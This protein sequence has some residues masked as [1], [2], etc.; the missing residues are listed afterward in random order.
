M[1][2]VCDVDVNVELE[3][4]PTPVIIGGAPTVS[5]RDGDDKG[6]PSLAGLNGERF[7]VPAPLSNFPDE[8]VFSFLFTSNEACGDSTRF[9]FVTLVGSAASDWACG[10]A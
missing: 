4:T 8:D 2:S 5:A 6:V 3:A 7:S 9:R 10:C 1:A